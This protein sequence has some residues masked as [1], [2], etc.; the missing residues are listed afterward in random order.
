MDKPFIKVENLNF[1]YSDTDE[2][3][4]ALHNVNLSIN[5]GEYVAWYDEKHASAIPDEVIRIANE[6]LEARRNK[7][8]AKSDELRNE[9]ARLGYLIKDSKDG[10][11]LIKNS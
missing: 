5:A 10:Y 4:P 3:I 8:W 9:L 2:N 7:D 11:E 6:R 1:S